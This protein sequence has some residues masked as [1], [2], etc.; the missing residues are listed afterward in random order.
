MDEVEGA[1]VVVVQHWCCSREVLE[2]NH[3]LAVSLW[4]YRRQ[5]VSSVVDQ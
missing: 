5:E 4:V 2:E 1:R 3:D